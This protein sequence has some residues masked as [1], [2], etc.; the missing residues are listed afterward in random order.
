MSNSY[1]EP[2][3]VATKP[4]HDLGCSLGRITDWVD[5]AHGAHY[6]VKNLARDCQVTPRTLERFFCASFG[7]PPRFWL[8]R[9][10]MK[11]AV[12]LLLDRLNV[13]ETADDLGYKS[14]SHFS[15]EFKRFYGFPPNRRARIVA[16]M[17]AAE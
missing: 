14:P 2:N 4:N 13:S 9:A 3:L 1:L 16:K 7:Q 11:R 15:R 12:E 6:S 5:R 10:R 17:S 8:K